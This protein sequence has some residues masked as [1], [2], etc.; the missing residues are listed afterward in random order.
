M[1][2]QLNVTAGLLGNNLGNDTVYYQ[3]EN[4]DRLMSSS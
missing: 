2:W 1:K 4:N 3:L